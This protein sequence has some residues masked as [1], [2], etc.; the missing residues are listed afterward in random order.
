MIELHNEELY[1]IAIAAYLSL[2]PHVAIGDPLPALHTF[3]RHGRVDTRPF[4]DCY[5]CFPLARMFV[6]NR[7]TNAIIPANGCRQEIR[8]DQ[9][10]VYLHE[11]ERGRISDLKILDDDTSDM[12]FFIRFAISI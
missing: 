11:Y 1:N 4:R 10:Q 5:E 8:Q 12:Y 9:G 7:T 3:V 6:I 2:H